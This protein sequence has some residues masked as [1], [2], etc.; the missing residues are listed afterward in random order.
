MGEIRKVALR[1]RST[2]KLQ[3]SPLWQT[4]SISFFIFLM[5]PYQNSGTG[6]LSCYRRHQREI[7][8][9][10]L[11]TVFHLFQELT[12]PTC[13][14]NSIPVHEQRASPY[15]VRGASVPALGSFEPRSTHSY[16]QTSPA[17]ELAVAWAGSP[18]Q[19]RGW[20]SRDTAFSRY[21]APGCLFPTDS[22]VPK[23]KGPAGAM[24]QMSDQQVSWNKSKGTRLQDQHVRLQRSA[25]TSCLH[26]PPK[27]G[28]TQLLSS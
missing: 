24:L 2:A 27:Q 12:L 10:C 5:S 19:G 9:T 21:L 25:P 11:F 22:E 26:S 8:R 28:K 3:G 16:P 1:I 6:C 23:Q 20:G 13:C 14:Q 15:C 4:I 7:L 18:A 17:P